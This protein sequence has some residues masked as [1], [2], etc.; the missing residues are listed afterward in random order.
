MFIFT[1]TVF[2]AAFC[3]VI[4]FF[5][6][7]RLELLE[8]DLGTTNYWSQ[9]SVILPLG[10]YNCVRLTSEA[11]RKRKQPRPLLVRTPIPFI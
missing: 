9:L 5:L 8:S 2:K 3:S 7:S 11:N 10:S 4:D 6:V 1:T